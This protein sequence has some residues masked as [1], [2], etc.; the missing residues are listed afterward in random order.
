MLTVV[1]QESDLDL[2]GELSQGQ[3]I[4]IFVK[5]ELAGSLGLL[6]WVK[7]D[8]KRVF[9]T[10]KILIPVFNLNKRVQ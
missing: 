8:Q 10:P 9:L 7:C 2:G 6:K 4:T 3:I 5:H 1:L